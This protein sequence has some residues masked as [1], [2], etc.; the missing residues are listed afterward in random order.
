MIYRILKLILL[1][2]KIKK[3]IEERRIEIKSRKTHDVSNC[4]PLKKKNQSSG[5]KQSILTEENIPEIKMEK[6]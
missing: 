3:I 5:R 2:T 1:N 6:T 4:T